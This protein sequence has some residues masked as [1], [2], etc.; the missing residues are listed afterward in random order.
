MG[1]LTTCFGK[2]LCLIS[3]W[4]AMAAAVSWQDAHQWGG[5]QMKMARLGG[6]CGLKDVVLAM[7]ALDLRFGLG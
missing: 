7:L 3:L 5:F 1:I 2:H 6:P 4:S